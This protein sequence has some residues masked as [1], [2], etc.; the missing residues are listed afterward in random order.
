[1][2]MSVHA[3]PIGTPETPQSCEQRVAPS[4]HL[5]V[6]PAPGHKRTGQP[7]DGGVLGPVPNGRPRR[8]NRDNETDREVVYAAVPKGSVRAA[9]GDQV[10]AKLRAHAG[11]SRCYRNRRAN[12]LAVV[13]VLIACVDFQSMTTRPGWEL[14]AESAR[15]HRST[16]GRILDQLKGWGFVGVVASGRL[17]AHAA[18]DKGGVF[19]NEAAVYVLCIPSLMAVVSTESGSVAVDENATPPAACGTPVFVVN[20]TPTRTREK[21]TQIETATPPLKAHLCGV[22]SS[23]PAAQVPWRPETRWPLHRTPTRKY[24][25]AA[26]AAEI[27]YRLFP[28]RCMNPADI[29]HVCRDYFLAG[30][31]VADILHALD[32]K[33]DGTR[34]PHSGAPVTKNAGRM[35]GWMKTR[36]ADWQLPTGEIM[37]SKDQRATAEREALKRRQET[38]KH[39]ILER[40]AEHAARLNQGD[41]PTKIKALAQIRALGDQPSIHHGR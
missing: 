12:I 6:V 32:W 15:I 18:A 19:M 3:R 26:A 34:W 39:R 29:A 41:S 1:M 23:A 27:H 7:L 40:Q 38:D 31:T 36:L 9:H 10:R 20:E 4:R 33:A 16:V 17:A 37:R 25:R 13:D 28:V 24:Q 8:V 30:Y 22:A 11:F 2:S 5:A 21:S 35:R 14:I